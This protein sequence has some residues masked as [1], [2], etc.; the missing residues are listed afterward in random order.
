MNLKKFVSITYRSFLIVAFCILSAIAGNSLIEP[1]QGATDTTEE[2]ATMFAQDQSD[3]RDL[4]NN[5]RQ[6]QWAKIAAHDKAHYERVLDLM[7]QDKLTTGDEFYYAAMIMQHGKDQ[8]DYML[9]HI[10]AMAAAQRGN[11]AA[12]WLSAASFDRLMQSAGQPQVFGTQFFCKANEPYVISE[13]M[14]P[15][16]ITDSVRK[17]FNVPSLE[18]N[19]QRLKELNSNI[20]P[21][22]NR[23]K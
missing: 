15:T 17:A 14:E 1:A 2:L 22:A 21:K 7:R 12:V 19:K 23:E 16:L 3:R 11:K 5:P 20:T 18:Q 8:K 10:F 6:D 9:A 4:D 13:P